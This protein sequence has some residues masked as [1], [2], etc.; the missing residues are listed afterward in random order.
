LIALIKVILMAPSNR[1]VA[2]KAVVECEISNPSPAQCGHESW[3]FYAA[4]RG[5]KK[6]RYSP[7]T[8][9]LREI[10]RYQRSTDLLMKKLP[11]SRLVR[12]FCPTI[13][14][15]LL[16]VLLLVAGPRNSIDI[17]SCWWR[18]EMA[19]SSYTSFTGSIRSAPRSFVW[20]YK[21]LCDICEED[22]NYA[23]RYAVGEESQGNVGGAWLLLIGLYEFLAWGRMYEWSKRT[24]VV[25]NAAFTL[26]H[27]TTP[28]CKQLW[29]KMVVCKC[30]HMKE[31]Q[32]HLK[33]VSRFWISPRINITSLYP[34]QYFM[35][36]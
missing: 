14:V 3:H 16:T 11:F 15:R 20:G 19:I 29:I 33:K 30:K 1:G 28:E 31:H 32:F 24:S 7:G 9:A 13:R 8:V 25:L 17:T 23:K 18:N 36:V 21:S 26:P 5:R 4:A 27:Q 10:R 6:H 22:D 12:V 34:Q 35:L 2:A